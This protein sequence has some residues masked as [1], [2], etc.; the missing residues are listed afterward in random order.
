[1]GVLFGYICQRTRNIVAPWLAHG[2][3]IV[4]LI[5]VGAMT[6]VQFTP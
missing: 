2:L 4:A 1:M 3:W 6:F 5:L